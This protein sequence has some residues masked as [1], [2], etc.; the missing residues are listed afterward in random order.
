MP[1]PVPI[2]KRKQIRELAHILLKADGSP[3]QRA[4]ARVTDVDNVTVKNILGKEPLPAE[5]PDAEV[6][7]A[8]ISALVNT[9]QQKVSDYLA[10]GWENTVKRYSLHM[11]DMNSDARDA[12]HLAKALDINT[13]MLQL[14]AG[15]VT[16][17]T[18][19]NQTKQTEH[20]V[21][22]I[23]VPEKESAAFRITRGLKE[24]HA[25]VNVVDNDHE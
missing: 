13:K 10:E 1:A 12:A 15:R 4:I 20:T 25:P 3:N 7:Q 8:H 17:R 11:A 6:I 19:M 22:V 14:L 23:Q 5:R 18:Q 9:S 16:S 21:M 2:T 24:I